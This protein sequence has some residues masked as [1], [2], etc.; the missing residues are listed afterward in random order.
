MLNLSNIV[1]RIK[2]KL[3]IATLAV[4]FDDIDQMI[5]K[6][7]QD[8]TVPVFSLYC[9]D[10]RLCRVELNKA[11]KMVNRVTSSTEYLLPDFE[12]PK[13]LYVN[14]VYY[15]EDALT[16]LGY[17]AGTVPMGMT[18][19]SFIGQMMLNNLSAQLLNQA[20]P[21]MTFHFEAPR[22]L[23]LYN[24][25]WSNVVTMDWSFEHSKSLNTIPDDALTSFLQLALLDVKEN[26]YPTMAQFVEQNTVYGTLR[27]PIDSWQNAES[28]RLELLSR[29]D[30]TYHLDGIPFWWG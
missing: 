18:D 5:T 15:N 4:P 20:V 27:L 26:L 28:E 12:N 8:F 13:L 30:D 24:A 22:K 6:I 3:G 29:W 11:F 10:R 14:D 9:P 17:Y 21:K 1:S 19:T 7:I 25:F 23:I 16:N 2:F